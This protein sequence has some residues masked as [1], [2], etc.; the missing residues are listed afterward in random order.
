MS[1]EHTVE[2][3]EPVQSLEAQA[4]LHERVQARWAE[5]GENYLWA[6]LPGAV[7]SMVLAAFWESGL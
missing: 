3:L 1:A 6:R 5:L 4:S 7:G 2:L